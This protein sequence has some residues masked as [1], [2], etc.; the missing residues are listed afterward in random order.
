MSLDQPGNVLPRLN[1]PKTNKTSRRAM[2]GRGIGRPQQAFGQ[3]NS[4]VEINDAMPRHA[5]RL[6]DLPAYCFRNSD[7][8]LGPRND[9]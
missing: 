5:E 8:A 3:I 9:G 2:K 7:N 1:G 6:H 4:L